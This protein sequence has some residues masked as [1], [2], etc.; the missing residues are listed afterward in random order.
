MLTSEAREL[1]MGLFACL[2]V[3]RWVDEVAATGPYLDAATLLDAARRASA[4]LSRAEVDEALVHHPRIGQ[5]ARDASTAARFS[6]REQASP[7][8]DDVKLSELIAAGNRDYEARFGRVF[9]IRVAGRTRAE[10]L[11]ELN[12]RL[13]LPN[14]VEVGIVAGE[15]RE[16]ALLRL[17]ALIELR[18]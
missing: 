5:S 18:L 7:D 1:R 17:A 9:L 2:G 12:R 16:I 3:E 15:L 10:I 11:A 4:T 14:D 13:L 8:A 6:R